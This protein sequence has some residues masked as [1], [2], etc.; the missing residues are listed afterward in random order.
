[1]VRKE[2]DRI[3]VLQ[4]TDC[5]PLSLIVSIPDSQEVCAASVAALYIPQGLNL[6]L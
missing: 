2:A 6:V 4:A 1:M 3:K 5:I